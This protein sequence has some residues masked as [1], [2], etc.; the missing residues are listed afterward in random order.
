M[1][2]RSEPSAGQRQYQKSSTICLR[3]VIE[4]RFHY[5]L[6]KDSP[7]GGSTTY[8]IKMAPRMVHYLQEKGDPKDVIIPAR[9][10]WPYGGSTTC[11]RKVAQGVSTTCRRRV[12]L[13]T[14]HHLPNYDIFLDD[15]QGPRGQQVCQVSNHV[16]PS[17]GSRALGYI[18]HQGTS[19]WGSIPL[20]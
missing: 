6:E 16:I 12:T 19:S 14:F 8:E 2:V 9:E 4:R 17:C 20:V 10:K 3:K 1:I 11:G 18:T 15:A 13:W 5:L 7:Q